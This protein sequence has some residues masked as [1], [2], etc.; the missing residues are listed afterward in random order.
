VAAPDDRLLST[1]EV[2]E[3]LQVDEQTVRRWIKSGKLEAFKPG[4]EWRIHPAAL[5]ALLETYSSPKVI[6]SP[7]QEGPERRREELEELHELYSDIKEGVNHLSAVWEARLADD[8]LN[9]GGVKEFIENTSRALIPTLRDVLSTELGAIA[10]VLEMPEEE[11]LDEDGEISPE[12]LSLSTL[13]P[14]V[15][16]FFAVGRRVEE[17]WI[18][19]FASTDELEAASGITDLDRFRAR[20][21]GASLRSRRVG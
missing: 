11:M 12:L 2:A 15:D 8:D 4:R 1:E 20:K 19:R 3:R 10:R 17:A 7:E 9:P 13:D 5:E 6:A 16:R 18:T 21:D 14:V